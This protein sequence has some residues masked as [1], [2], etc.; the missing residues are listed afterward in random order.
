[1]LRILSLLNNGI[2]GRLLVAWLYWACAMMLNAVLGVLI[3]RFVSSRPHVSAEPLV[4]F[5]F[6]LLPYIQPK[7]FGVSIPDLC[8]LV[9]A[10]LV[11]L[12]LVVHFSAPSA[13]ILLRRVLVISAT[14]YLG[15]AI[16]IPQTLLPNP[17]QSCVPLL[18]Y[19]SVV[20]SAMM[21]P[22]GAA[23]TCSDVFYSGHTI[24]ITCAILVWTDYMRGNHLRLLGILTSSLALLGIIA[25]RFHYTLDVFYGAIV[26]FFIWRGYHFALRCP[27]VLNHFACISWWESE[28]AMGDRRDQARLS[29]VYRLDLSRDPRIL[30]SF[31]EKKQAP[32]ERKKG[33]LSKAQLLLLL[34]VTL[35]LSP[36]WIAVYRGAS[37]FTS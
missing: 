6:E 31:T 22:F 37:S 13:T 28:D 4:D 29:G 10:T 35:T 3:Q 17:D 8:S 32:A 23:I 18:P 34:V 1:M 24:P 11:A 7:S 26:T 16:S 2:C 21:V 30:W 5:G 14:S 15:R 27:A 20:V 19:G 12:S 33:E 9:S 36:S 25:T